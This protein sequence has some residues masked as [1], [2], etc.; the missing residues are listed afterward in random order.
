[1][2][3]WILYY[4]NCVLI[5]TRCDS[6]TMVITKFLWPEFNRAIQEELIDTKFA[7]FGEGLVTIF[8]R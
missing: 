7:S 5:K 3:H 1:M 4:N 8:S 2:H 6:V